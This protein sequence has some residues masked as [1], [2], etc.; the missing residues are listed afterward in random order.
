[1]L[2]A[3][4]TRADATGVRKVCLLPYSAMPLCGVEVGSS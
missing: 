3:P 1:M 2:N 4:F